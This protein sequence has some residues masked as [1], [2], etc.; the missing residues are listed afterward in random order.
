[1]FASPFQIDDD[2]HEAS[3]LIVDDTG[4]S[5]SIFDDLVILNLYFG[6]T[7][8]FILVDCLCILDK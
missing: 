2:D 4:S 7:R 5:Q 1:M 8:I 6:W 3:P